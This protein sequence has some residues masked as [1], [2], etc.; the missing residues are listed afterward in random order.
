MVIWINIFLYLVC[1]AI[2]WKREGLQSTGKERGST[3]GMLYPIVFLPCIE[4]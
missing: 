1:V 2:N 4:L 3:D